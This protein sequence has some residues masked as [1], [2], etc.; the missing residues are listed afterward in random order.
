MATNK[1]DQFNELQKKNLEAAMRL[2]QL[3]IE[4]SQRV[5]EIQVATAKSL[6]EEG[7]QNAKALSSIKDPKQAVELRTQYA[8]TTTE[9]MLSCARE[10]AEITTRTQ[11][12]VGKLVGEQLTTG[13]AD[14]F[15]A[16]QKL[17]KGMPITDQNAMGAM[18]TAM[19]TTRAA[20]EQMTRAS[21]EAFQ[22][23][24]QGG[25]RK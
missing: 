3:S 9:R 21:A 17:F 10:I 24:T 18:Q 12:E 13:S 19:D 8:Q 23:F 7:V 25:K 14:V 5:M 16:M 2:A 6:F 1:Q 4:N 11:A 22:A 20:F 15:E